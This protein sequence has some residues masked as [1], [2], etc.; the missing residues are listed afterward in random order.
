MRGSSSVHSCESP[1][2]EPHVPLANLRRR[3]PCRPGQGKHKDICDDK[4]PG[5]PVVRAA[6]LP[7]VCSRCMPLLCAS[8]KSSWC[9]CRGHGSMPGRAAPVWVSASA[10]W[11]GACTIVCMSPACFQE[12]CESFWGQPERTP[13]ITERTIVHVATPRVGKH[14]CP[15]NGEGQD[16]PWTLAVCVDDCVHEFHGQERACGFQPQPNSNVF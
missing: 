9:R 3:Q 13:T 15:Y 7:G 12:A 14:V 1:A 4:S 8:P 2:S 6:V 5:T 16:I 11:R 10:G